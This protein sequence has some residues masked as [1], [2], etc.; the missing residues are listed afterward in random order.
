MGNVQENFR[1]G[2]SRQKLQHSAKTQRETIQVVCIQ[3]LIVSEITFRM[4]I[5]NS[6]HRWLAWTHAYHQEIN[7]KQVVINYPRFFRPT[8]DILFVFRGSSLMGYLQK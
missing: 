7:R 8:K 4:I 6:S 2:H 1:E 3:L 5:W